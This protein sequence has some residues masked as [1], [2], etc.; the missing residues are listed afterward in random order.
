M[1]H[2]L[3]TFDPDDGEPNGTLCYCETGKDHDGAGNLM[4]PDD[5]ANDD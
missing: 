2:W 1:T 4:F 3:T 5:E